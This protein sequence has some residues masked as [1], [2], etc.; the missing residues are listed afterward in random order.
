MVAVCKA[1]RGNPAAN[2][3]WSHAGSTSSYK[4]LPQSDGFVTV[5]SRLEFPEHADT[6]NL[7]CFVSHPFWDQV[8]IVTVKEAEKAVK[9]PW[10]YIVIVVVAVVLVGSLSFTL[11]KLITWRRSQ[12]DS[13]SSKLPEEEYVEEVEPY[14]SYVQRVNS[15]YN[16]SADLFTYSKAQMSHTVTPTYV[17]NS[18]PASEP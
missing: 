9:F 2:I 7:S 5:E 14:A 4:V 6:T 12:Q 18:F 17:R 11:K 8:K 13:S 15:I 16:S 3:S 10:L 1:E